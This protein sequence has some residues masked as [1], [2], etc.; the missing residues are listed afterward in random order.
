MVEV[1]KA[2][3]AAKTSVKSNDSLLRLLYI[4]IFMRL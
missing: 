2:T 1:S 4:V 3:D